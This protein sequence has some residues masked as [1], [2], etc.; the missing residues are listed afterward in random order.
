[1]NFCILIS[2]VYEGLVIDNVKENNEKKWFKKCIVCLLGTI[3]LIA[4]MVYVFDPYFHFHKPFS[5]VSYRLYDER[6][7]NDGI[8]RHFDY[9]AIITGTSMAQNYKPSE[10]DAL[11]GTKTIKATFSGAG[12][13]ELSQNLE[14]ALTRNEECK[15]VIWSLDYNALIRE[16]DYTQYA[17]YPT[18]LYDDEPWND[19]SYV[20]NK[21]I[22]YHGVMTN[23]ARTVFRVP[24]TTMDEYSEWVKPI[25]REYV[26]E[27]YAKEEPIDY[28]T[29]EL[30]ED[31]IRMVRENITENIV[32]LAN[33]YP[34]TTFYL[35]Y[36]PYSIVYWHSH[37]RDNTMER[38]FQAEKLATELI[39][40]CPN[41]RLYNFYENY[42]LVCNLDN[43]R[44][45][46]HYSAEVNSL[47]L[48]L[49]QEDTY[50]VT[51][52]NYIEKLAKE[53]EFYQ[54]YDYDSI[55]K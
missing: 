8:G 53:K 46:E 15:T 28:L 4:V 42:D 2:D 3:G 37:V 25:G 52:D 38:Q 13:Q 17:D 1:M 21:S 45:K 32:N 11:F 29:P 20:F 34:D 14:R 5:F 6:Y 39:L 49:L 7:T 26:L 35:F 12:Y 16:A 36:T 10:V 33:K 23:V 19:V 30:T 43:Y 31:E 40:Q 50:L 47:L 18:Y 41:I 22:F 48:T 55:F 51:K 54:N 9:D 44:D 24:S 27:V